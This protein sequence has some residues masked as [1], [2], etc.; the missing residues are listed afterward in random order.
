MIQSAY[1][2]TMRRYEQTDL[3]FAKFNKVSPWIGATLNGLHQAAIE[4]GRIASGDFKDKFPKD[5]ESYH[6]LEEMA[7]GSFPIL[8]GMYLGKLAYWHFQFPKDGE[9]LPKIE[10]TYMASGAMIAWTG[11]FMTGIIIHALNG[12]ADVKWGPFK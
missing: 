3:A 5:W 2:R 8:A 4:A 10:F 6:F 7:E 11:F 1:Y 9:Y 12:P